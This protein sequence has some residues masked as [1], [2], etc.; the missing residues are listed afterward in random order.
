MNRRTLSDSVGV[1]V[2]TEHCRF[3]IPIRFLNLPVFVTFLT[4]EAD[5]FSD[6]LRLLD[7]DEELVCGKL[8]A[9]A[10]VVEEEAANIFLF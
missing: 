5:F 2:S 1:Y 9:V 4:C 7:K 10:M 3:V 8:S 6:V